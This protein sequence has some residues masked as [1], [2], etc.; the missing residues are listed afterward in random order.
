MAL[1]IIGAVTQLAVSLF[2][3]WN[4]SGTVVAFRA[5]AAVPLAV[6]LTVAALPSP[7]IPASGHAAAYYATMAALVMANVSPRRDDP[8]AWRPSASIWAWFAALLIFSGLAVAAISAVTG[9]D[10][11]VLSF[12][13]TAPLLVVT[14]PFVASL[15]ADVTVIALPAVGCALGRA[16]CRPVMGTLSA[17]LLVACF[18]RSSFPDPVLFGRSAIAL[19]LVVGGCVTAWCTDPLAGRVAPD[20]RFTKWGAAPTTDLTFLLRIGLIGAWTIA[21]GAIAGAVGE[22]L[23]LD[24]P[25]RSLAACAVLTLLCALA[26]TF[27]AYQYWP[28]R[29]Q[30]PLSSSAALAFIAVVVVT[31]W[32]LESVLAPVDPVSRAT[33]APLVLLGWPVLASITLS[34]LGTACRLVFTAGRD[35]RTRAGELSDPTAPTLRP[36]TTEHSLSASRSPTS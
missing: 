30:A 18:L 28:D 24:L 14:V 21:A 10:P 17:V 12:T 16:G 27:A 23:R 3:S 35:A 31:R 20:P 13:G 2:P 36:V 6:G 15:L 7:P 29:R 8:P 33:I 22:S 34:A 19:P 1:T 32:A 5:L 25:F 9:A 11:L 26:W 4:R